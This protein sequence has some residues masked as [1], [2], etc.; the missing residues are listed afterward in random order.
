VADWHAHCSRENCPQ[1]C[2]R[3]DCRKPDSHL[4]QRFT[5]GI[6]YQHNLAIFDCTA[7]DPPPAPALNR[8]GAASLASP[9]GPSSP[10]P[11][12]G[13]PVSSIEQDRWARALSAQTLKAGL[14]EARA[15]KAVRLIAYLQIRNNWQPVPIAKSKGAGLL[16]WSERTWGR[17]VQAAEQLGWIRREVRP[18]RVRGN[19]RGYNPGSIFTVVW[20]SLP[21]AEKP[22]YRDRP[23]FQVAARLQ[24]RRTAWQ[25]GDNGASPD[26][27][28]GPVGSSAN[29]VPGWAPGI[30]RAVVNSGRIQQTGHGG[31]QP[32]H[33]GENLNTEPGHVE[34]ETG[35][36]SEFRTG[37]NLHPVLPNGR[38]VSATAEPTAVLA[39]NGGTF[40][41]PQPPPQGGGDQL[42]S[43]G[44]PCPPAL[45]AEVKTAAWYRGRR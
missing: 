30:E 25:N 34:R 3:P 39:S 22:N 43:K 5:R 14:L 41:T 29:Q 18:G 44:G 28:G 2:R 10:H 26:G 20:D 9:A 42:E 21:R 19:R 40:P 45:A 27:R 4:F 15:S 13:R 6:G 7:P 31:V 37:P 36:G 1:R 23:A 11:A 12:M 8:R 33:G 32:G 35:Q 24:Q 38:D 16:Q 17:A